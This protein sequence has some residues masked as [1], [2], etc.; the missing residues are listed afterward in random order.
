MQASF[1]CPVCSNILQ[2]ET[3]WS[4][5]QTQCPYC[6]NLID[7]PEFNQPTAS[8]RCNDFI[9]VPDTN[10]K[11]ESSNSD[12]FLI[13]LFEFIFNY[14]RTF[15]FLKN[16]SVKTRKN[17]I[18]SG[19]ILYLF[20][21]IALLLGSS[22]SLLGITKGFGY[23]I[24]LIAFTTCGMYMYKLYENIF[25]KSK[26]YSISKPLLNTIATISCCASIYFL[27]C[28]IMDF[29]KD[30]NVLKSVYKNLNLFLISFPIF[31]IALFPSG[32]S[33]TLKEDS[34]VDTAIDIWYYFS[35]T[36]LFIVPFMWFYNAAYRFTNILIHMGADKEKFAEAYNT[37]TS[38]IHIGILFPI[39]IYIA[40]VIVDFTISASKTFL[41]K[42]ND[43]NK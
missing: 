6:K 27:A 26:E 28:G 4:G 25:S 5:Q 13:R 8:V 33:I 36:T 3:T 23:M 14:L 1:N 35:R 10:P 32:I 31:I 21:A 16:L 19:A 29:F 20:L 18:Q 41:E 40:Y 42:L 24:S 7:I 9:P 37:S 12:F 30:E 2:T 22:S 17:L 11:K 39:Y 43:N 38:N 15:V 34:T